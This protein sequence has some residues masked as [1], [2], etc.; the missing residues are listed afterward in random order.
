M[1]CEMYNEG[2][3]DAFFSPARRISPGQVSGSDKVD[4]RVGLNTREGGGGV[5]SGWMV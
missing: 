1:I 2:G 5:R 3:N 4:Q